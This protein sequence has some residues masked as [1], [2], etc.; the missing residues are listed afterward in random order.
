MLKHMVYGL[1]VLL[2]MGCADTSDR[3]RDTHQ[4]ELP[5][6][7]PIDHTHS[8]A[9]VGMDDLKPKSSALA[10]LI[11]FE[12]DGSKPLLT[13]KTR[14]DRAWDMVAVALKISNIEVLDK[15]REEN[16][17]QV[18]Y[19]PDTAGKEE[20]LLD[21]FASDNYA[22]AEYLITLQ[23]DILGIRVNAALAKPDELEYGDDASA[24]LLR[25]L[26]KVI[27][28]KIINREPNKSEE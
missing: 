8:Q 9:A 2:L 4:L 27:D 12:D 28:E 25:F 20:S 13:L 10:N 22:E 5:P 15:N 23:E 6:E 24:E 21:I 18:R 1:P 14:P 26:H 19:D 7:L 16:R 17:I 3:Y 11:A